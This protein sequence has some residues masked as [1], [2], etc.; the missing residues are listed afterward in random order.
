MKPN[1]QSLYIET[2]QQGNL[3]TQQDMKPNILQVGDCISNGGVCAI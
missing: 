3:S 1:A 2:S